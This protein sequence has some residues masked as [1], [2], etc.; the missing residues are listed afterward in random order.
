MRILRPPLA[1]DKNEKATAPTNA[2]STMVTPAISSPVQDA[3]N[4][5]SEMKAEL[6]HMSGCHCLLLGARRSLDGVNG[7][8]EVSRVVVRCSWVGGTVVP[9]VVI[10]DTGYI[11]RRLRLR[12]SPT[13]AS[14]P[15]KFNPSTAI[16]LETNYES[17]GI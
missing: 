7:T 11:I 8:R 12:P 10:R 13:P 17:G 3:V 15:R 6:S 9:Q 5:L 2:T 16:Y 4:A 14:S 1:Q